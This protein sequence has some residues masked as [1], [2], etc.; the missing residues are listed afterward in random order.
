MSTRAA[1]S[2]LGRVVARRILTATGAGIAEVIISIGIP[3]AS[4][5]GRWKCSLLLEG[6]GAPRLQSVEGGDSLQALLLAIGI[7]RFDLDRTGYK[8]HWTD[9]DS[10]CGIPL[11][12]PTHYGRAFEERVNL[13]IE[14]DAKRILEAGVRR[15]RVDIRRWE[16]E[17]KKRKNL[18]A[19][20][21]AAI[22]RSKAALTR[23]EENLRNWQ[24]GRPSQT[25]NVRK[26]TR[27]D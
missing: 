25:A 22:E 12:V 19:A 15:R 7:A 24:P 1:K 11:Q 2:E 14:R 16:H 20:M 6:L 4:S 10:G 9:P 26:R 23:R 21:E 5:F 3:R 18:L 8:F 17:L 13:F 27:S